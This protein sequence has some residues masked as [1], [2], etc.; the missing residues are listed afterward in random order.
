MIKSE[1]NM[2]TL[3]LLSAAVDSLANSSDVE[4]IIGESMWRF[5]NLN[6]PHLSHQKA[7]VRWGR[8]ENIELLARNKRFALALTLWN[9]QPKIP[10]VEL[11]PKPLSI[12]M[13]W[14]KVEIPEFCIAPVI[15]RANSLIPTHP[16]RTPKP[17]ATIYIA[18]PTLAG[19]A[20]PNGQPVH[21][22]AQNIEPAPHVWWEYTKQEPVV[23][24][25]PAE[26]EWDINLPEL[27]VFDYGQLAPEWLP[28]WGAIGGYSPTVYT[29]ETDS[30]APL[31]AVMCRK[32]DGE[33]FPAVPSKIRTFSDGTAISI[34]G[35]LHTV[36][37]GSNMVGLFRLVE[38]R[39]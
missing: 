11:F 38:W 18:Q 7:T 24:D 6:D 12:V 33:M 32:P 27:I 23:F 29:W 35:N 10:P 31:G 13:E 20:Q 4:F 21:W 34:N 9:E 14:T 16:V 2:H 30:K 15:D 19:W 37:P 17:F 26:D 3:R 22:I 36:P 5:E 1:T 25:I 28:E 8:F 39:S